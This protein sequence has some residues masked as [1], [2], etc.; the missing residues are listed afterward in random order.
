M[1]VE[2]VLGPDSLKMSTVD[3][4]ELSPGE[5]IPFKEYDEEK[6][7]YFLAGRG[8]MSVYA[9]GEFGDVY[10]IRQDT[11][12]WITPSLGH[13]VENTGHLPLRFLVINA[14]MREGEESGR[15]G[16]IVTRVYDA[17]SNPSRMEGLNLTIRPIQIGN[18]QRFLGAEVNT[19][20]PHGT[21]RPH[22]H[23]NTEENNYVLVGEGIFHRDDEKIPCSSGDAFA[24]PPGATRRLENKGLH[25][26][27]YINYVTYA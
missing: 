17:H 4:V 14:L 21:S 23:D 13:S 16:H 19:I 1:R 10:E 20:A 22:V 2:Q 6:I 8:I 9:E 27:N 5:N 26:L 25:P 11:A 18:S 3:D 15:A 7:Y 12:V 24:Y